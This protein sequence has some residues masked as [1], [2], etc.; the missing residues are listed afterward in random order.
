MRPLLTPDNY[1]PYVLELVESAHDELLIQNQTFNAPK[2]NHD[3]LRALIDAVI[4]KQRAGVKVRIIFRLVLPSVARKV[5]EELRD[6]GV[7]LAGVKVQPNCHTKGIIVDRRQVLIGS[8]NWSNDGVSVNRDASLLFD[9]APLARYFAE[10]FDHDWNNLARQNI[11]SESLPV[12]LAPDPHP[13]PGMAR[14]AWKEYR[15]LP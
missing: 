8:Q 14:L 7:D 3:A 11:G 2:D 13:L 4:A 15:Q 9:D 12:R 10:I 5:L 1:F 6:Y